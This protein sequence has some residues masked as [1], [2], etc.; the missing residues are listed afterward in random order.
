MTAD[1]ATSALRLVVVRSLFWT[2]PMLAASG[3]ARRVADS[4]RRF[5]EHIVVVTFYKIGLTAVRCRT[6]RDRLEGSRQVCALCGSMVVVVV[7]RMML[8][9]S[10]KE[11]AV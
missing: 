7:V 4:Q 3:K 1:G 10:G 9:E 11:V 2:G 5:D 6:Q 8:D